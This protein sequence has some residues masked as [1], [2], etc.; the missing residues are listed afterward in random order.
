MYVSCLTSSRTV[1]RTSVGSF[2]AAVLFVI[3]EFFFLDLPMSLSKYTKTN[4]D[5]LLRECAML[6]NNG[7]DFSRLFNQDQIHQIHEEFR[8]Q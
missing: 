7:R 5:H 6:R 1:N 2:V 3:P 4:I 8:H